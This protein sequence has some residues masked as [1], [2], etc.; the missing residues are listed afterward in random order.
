MLM[1]SFSKHASKIKLHF[2]S[3][4]V[5]EINGTDTIRIL[6]FDQAQLVDL[7]FVG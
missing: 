3:P 2:I 5:S 4:V 1:I 6:T 7:Y